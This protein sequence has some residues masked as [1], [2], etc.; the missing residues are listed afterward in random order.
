MSLK[1]RIFEFDNY[2]EFLKE[3]CAELKLID[4][5]FSWRYFAKVAGFKSHNFIKFVISGKSNLSS[6][7]IPKVAKALKL[8]RE[9]TRFFENLVL[10]NQ[11]NHTEEKQKYARELLGFKRFQEAFPLAESQFSFYNHWYYS[12]IRELPNLPDFSEDPEWIA[13]RLVPKITAAEAQKALDALLKLGLLKREPDGKLTQ[14][15][16]LITTHD[17]VSSAYV[18]EFH[19][20]FLDLASK[21]IDNTSRERREISAVTL[22]ISFESAQKI[23]EMIQTFRRDLMRIAEEHQTVETV[24][25]VGFQLFPLIK[26]KQEK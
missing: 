10:F 12:P 15:D 8:N 5:K 25:Q 13:Q 1:K 23:K 21:S 4:K 16:T 22:G 17:E 3:R 20:Q 14:S 2:R 11:T 19:R 26:M 18:S 6:I 24:Y 7:S 9:E